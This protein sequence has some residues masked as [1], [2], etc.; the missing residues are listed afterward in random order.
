MMAGCDDL[1]RKPF[2]EPEGEGEAPGDVLT[3]ETLAE[4]PDDLI[5]SVI[6]RIRQLNGPVADGLV[7]LAEDY[8]YDKL[9]ALIQQCEV[10]S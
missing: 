8:Q 2:Q 10:E 5:Q 4:L 3:P 1:V 9:L 7:D 6:E